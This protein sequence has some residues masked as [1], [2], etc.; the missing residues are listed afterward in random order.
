MNDRPAL[1]SPT[2]ALVLLLGLTLSLACTEDDIRGAL[3]GDDAERALQAVAS[4]DLS[5]ME[6][7]IAAIALQDV[8]ATGSSEDAAMAAASAAETTFQPSG[9]VQ[10]NTAGPTVTYQLDACSGPYG[11]TSVTGSIAVTYSVANSTLSVNIAGTGISINNAEMTLDAQATVTDPSN[12]PTTIE[13]QTAGGGTAANGS[14]VTR[15]GTY[16][17]SYDE[18]AE[19][20][21]L[22]GV[23]TST[24]GDDTIWTTTVQTF[25][26]CGES[27]P[28]GQLEFTE[29]DGDTVLA[30]NFD[31]SDQPFFTTADDPTPRTVQLSCQE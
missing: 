22:D 16:T 5:R 7:A 20:L 30:V 31:G 4:S 10:V 12:A 25:E 6:S 1:L 17:V 19:C 18:M 2:R 13:I 21:S 14:V 3:G 15:T 29:N 23:W 8:D 24:L 26:K 28:E 9:C 11:L 27:C